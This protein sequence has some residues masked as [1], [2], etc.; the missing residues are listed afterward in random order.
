MSQPRDAGSAG[1]QEHFPA[2]WD[3]IRISLGLAKLGTGTLATRSSDLTDDLGLSV[4]QV[5]G[6]VPSQDGM[7]LARQG[8]GNGTALIFTRPGA[9]KPGLL[10]REESPVGGDLLRSCLDASRR[11]LQRTFS[12]ELTQGKGAHWTTAAVVEVCLQNKGGV[13]RFK[14]AGVQTS[15]VGGDLAQKSTEPTAARSSSVPASK[16]LFTQRSTGPTAARSSS[17][18]ASGPRVRQPS[19]LVK[20]KPSEDMCPEDRPPQDV[21]PEDPRPEDRRPFDFC[22]KSSRWRDRKGRYTKPPLDV[23]RTEPLL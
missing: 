6:L 16:P 12:A 17:V 1:E 7:P 2:P 11:Q 5:T 10:E 9:P 8:I 3:T 19:E 4:G 21:G 23:A 18:P 13:R 15:D 20:E 14:D 22:V